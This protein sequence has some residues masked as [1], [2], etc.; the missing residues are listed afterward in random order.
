MKV[1][2][3]ALKRTERRGCPLCGNGMPTVVASISDAPFFLGCT[4]NP[5][6]KD[7]FASFNVFECQACFL[8]FTDARLDETAYEELHSEAIGGVW[9]RHHNKFAEFCC[10]GFGEP[11]E[12]LEI[13]CSSNPIAKRITS[14]IKR[15][16]YCDML[17]TAPFTLSKNE[18]YV[19]AKFPFGKDFGKFDLILASHVFEHSDD[20]R[21]F[22]S[23]AISL[24]KPNGKLAISIPNF[25]EW[26]KQKYWNAITAEHTIYPFR[27]HML[28]LAMI[29]EAAM[30]TERF[31]SHS[32]FFCFGKSSGKASEGGFGMHP[33]QELVASW[34]NSIMSSVQKIEAAI[35]GIG[36][37]KPIFITGASHLSQYPILM[38]EKI[39]KCITNVID[40]SAWKENKRLYGTGITCKRFEYIKEF[41]KPAVILMPSPYKEEMRKQILALNPEAEIIEA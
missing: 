41:G 34:C 26:L 10:K 38:S 21:S 35:S 8:I 11:I 12:I 40:N 5:K 6:E 17:P 18:E 24:L 32:L 36:P 1:E 7:R 19:S 20:M 9:E 14:P 16:A 28:R 4:T 33:N 15:V 37:G 2:I 27:D 39:R 30:E 13:G 3:R 31:E 25:E 22:F 23:S 29:N